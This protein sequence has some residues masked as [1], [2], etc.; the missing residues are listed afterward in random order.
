MCS[1]LSR[2]WVWWIQGIAVLYLDLHEGADLCTANGTL[3]RLNAH[4]LGALNAQAHVATGENHC[5][6]GRGKANNALSLSLISDVCRSVIHT[7][8]VVHVKDCVVVEELL[9]NELELKSARCLLKELTICHLYRFFC[10]T[11]VVCRVERLNSYYNRVVIVLK[12]SKVVCSIEGRI[13]GAHLGWELLLQ[14]GWKFVSVWMGK[15]RICVETNIV[16]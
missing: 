11:C 4:D 10:P 12:G 8:D 16:I 3:V 6:L 9:L 1:H 13:Q 7:I 2:C 5:V 15:V 14:A